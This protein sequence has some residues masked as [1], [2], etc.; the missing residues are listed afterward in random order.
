MLELSV[1][2]CCSEPD[3]QQCNKGALEE[4]NFLSVRVGVHQVPL[5]PVRSDARHAMAVMPERG[6]ESR[7]PL[8]S[9][10]LLVFTASQLFLSQPEPHM[11]ARAGLAQQVKATGR[12]NHL[13]SYLSKCQVGLIPCPSPPCRSLLACQALYMSGCSS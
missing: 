3:V 2:Q 5:M 7:L 10:P 4:H 6:S 11:S 13:A 12:S 9:V 1:S 8:E